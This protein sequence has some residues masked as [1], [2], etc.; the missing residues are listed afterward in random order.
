MKTVMV[1]LL[2]SFI[3]MGLLQGILYADIVMQD[4]VTISG[5]DNSQ[6]P[7]GIIFNDGTKQTTSAQALV[8]SAYDDNGQYI[9]TLMS[10]N[11][12]QQQI[13]GTWSQVYIPSLKL[14]M[15]ISEIGQCGDLTPVYYK[16]T[17][18]T[19]Q[20]YIS[21]KYAL[22]LISTGGGQYFAPHGKSVNITYL[23][24]YQNSACSLLN[25]PAQASAVPVIEVTNQIPF[26]FPIVY[27]LH[28]EY[29]N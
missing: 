3:L 16:T 20:G 19:G 15:D 24:T 4:N 2:V 13:A 12:I 23:S 26:T 25:S 7:Y 18:C 17:N 8:P 22:N 27:P 6:Q 1:A 29:S 14:A 21:V 5:Q 11:A 10:Y 28:F 9:G